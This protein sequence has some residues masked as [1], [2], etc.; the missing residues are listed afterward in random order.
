M[1]TSINSRVFLFLSVILKKHYHVSQLKTAKD[2]T[3][4]WEITRS[5]ECELWRVQSIEQDHEN[6]EACLRQRFCCRCTAY[7]SI[8][9]TRGRWRRTRRRR[10]NV[11]TCVRA[12]SSRGGSA[13]SFRGMETG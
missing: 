1:I 6:G 8:N 13:E 4:D 11:R 2:L 9:K 10:S 7:T 5:I 12:V 3:A